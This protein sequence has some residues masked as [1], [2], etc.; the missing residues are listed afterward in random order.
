M[1]NVE[2]FEMKIQGIIILFFILTQTDITIEKGISRNVYLL[3]YLK[4]P[5]HSD[6]F[7]VHKY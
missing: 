1:S 7:Y 5:R 6:F 4:T 3:N 2:N